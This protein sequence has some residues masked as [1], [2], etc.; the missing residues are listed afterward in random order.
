VGGF[1]AFEAVEPFFLFVR[2]SA[3]FDLLEKTGQL[4]E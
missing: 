3:E 2:D 4:V 1:I